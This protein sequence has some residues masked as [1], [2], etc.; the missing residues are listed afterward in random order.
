[1]EVDEAAVNQIMNISQLP[2]LAGHI[3]IMPDVHMGKGATVG[4]VIPTRSTIIPA[5]VGVDIGC[6]MCAVMTNLK[7]EDLPE[8]LFAL[9]NQIERAIPVGFNEHKAGIPAVSGP[10]AG[11][12]RKNLR[13]TLAT[14]PHYSNASMS[15]PNRFD[16]NTGQALQAKERARCGTYKKPHRIKLTCRSVSAVMRTA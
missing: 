15:V 2:I 5:A 6:G 1:M 11:I 14:L 16:S 8:S 13:K 3:A 12:L 10:Y 4:S 7:A 9:R